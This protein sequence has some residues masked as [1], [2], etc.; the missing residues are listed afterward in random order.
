MATCPGIGAGSG[1]VGGRTLTGPRSRRVP[2]PRG[3]AGRA[4]PGRPAG[5]S[6]CRRDRRRR[7]G[8]PGSLGNAGL[9]APTHDGVDQAIASTV[10]KVCLLEA[11]PLPAVPIVRKAQVGAQV[12][13]GDLACLRRVRLEQDHLLRRERD[14]RPQDLARARRVF[15]G[16]VV[17]MGARGLLGRELQHVLAQRGDHDGRRRIRLRSQVRRTLHRLQVVPH[18]R[19]RLAVLVAAHALDHGRVRHAEPEH[20]PAAGQLS[21]RLLDGA[22]GHRVAGVDVGDA[23]REHEPLGLPSQVAQERERV[24]A[25]GLRHPQRVVAPRFQLTA[26]IGGRAGIEGVDPGPDSE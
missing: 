9:V 11:L 1:S 8:A 26:E 25:D 14:V 21:Q 3:S 12:L 4:P 13:P 24:A 5:R 6:G 22:H 10:G 17:G 20:E 2:A 19:H 18:R 23:R 7:P 16:D 15:G